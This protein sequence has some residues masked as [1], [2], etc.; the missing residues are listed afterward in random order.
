[1]KKNFVFVVFTMLTI[2]S[3]GCSK[4]VRM[5]PAVPD[6]AVDQKRDFSHEKLIAITFDD[7]PHKQ[8]TPELLN[9]LKDEGVK[10]TFFVLGS[11]V[12]D[13]PDIV[14]RMWCEGH[15]VGNHSY[16]HKQLTRLSPMQLQDEIVATNEA[17]TKLTGRKATLM[18]PPY[19]SYNDV[20][21]AWVDL[22][23]ILWSVDPRDWRYRNADTVYDYVISRAKDGDIILLHDLY[24]STIQA[25]ARIIRKLKQNGFVFVTVDQL[26]NAK[27]ILPQKGKVYC[28]IR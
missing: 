12:R 16:S 6:A 19:G 1:M 25:A 4:M 20:V 7:G 21:K 24:P 2:L 22:P 8:H 14:K 27:K 26:M 9:I 18:R 3:M 15:Q 11:K 17:I 28:Q 13:Y 23:I 5:E 10:A